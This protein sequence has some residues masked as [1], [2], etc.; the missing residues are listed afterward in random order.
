MS[1]AKSFQQKKETV[2]R[3]WHVVDVKG[4]VLGRVATEIA[5]LLMGK[6]KPT[7]T[8]HVDTGDYVV[9]INASEVIVTGNKESDK[10]YYSH[11]LY[12]GGFK[13]ETF[14]K[15]LARDPKQVIERAIYGMLPKNKLRPPR[16]KRLKIFAG[17]EHTFQA[18]VGKVDQA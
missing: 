12:P 9:V 2:K 14:D 11:S 8:T 18:N 13:Q 4:K 7:F 17:S 5:T 16:M 1:K 15:L 6:H 10:V 3:N